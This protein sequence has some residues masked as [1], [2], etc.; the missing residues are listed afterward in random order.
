[1][2]GKNLR[3]D[4]E[5]K[6]QQEV[7]RK[8]IE[9]KLTTQEELVKKALEKQKQIDKFITEKKRLP[10]TMPLGNISLFLSFITVVIIA[11]I[12]EE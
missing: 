7:G 3:P 8:M 2:L 1:F 4:L 6:Y 12:V 11:P 5:V 9:E 10:T